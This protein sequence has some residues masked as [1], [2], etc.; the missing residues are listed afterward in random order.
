M[1]ELSIEQ[2]KIFEDIRHVDE[3]GNEF[4]YARELQGTLHYKEWRNFCKVIKL[5]KSLVR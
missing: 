4:W 5:L 1:N 3:Q 2:K